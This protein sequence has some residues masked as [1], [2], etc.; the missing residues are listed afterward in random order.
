MPGERYPERPELARTV[1]EIRALVASAVAASQPPHVRAYGD[2]AAVLRCWIVVA[3]GQRALYQEWLRFGHDGMQ[4][5]F[6]RAGAILSCSSPQMLLLTQAS[7]LRQD[8]V[9]LLGG[10]L[11]LGRL[12]NRILEDALRETMN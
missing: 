6:S 5:G 7:L 3:R 8:T 4:S 9:R 11:R 2:M 12:G 10:S 1:E